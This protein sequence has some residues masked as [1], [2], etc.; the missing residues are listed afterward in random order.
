MNR[1]TML[2]LNA[3]MIACYAIVGHLL[4]NL[5]GHRGR[6][7][8]FQYAAPAVVVTVMLVIFRIMQGVT[9]VQYA[10]GDDEAMAIFNLWGTLWPVFLIGLLGV[11]VC[12]LTWSICALFHE[13]RLLL[14]PLAFL[15]VGLL[16]Q[17]FYTVAMHFPSV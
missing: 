12:Q 6:Y 4:L 16:C 1:E 15:G 2:L 10:A 14:A 5:A 11:G 17:T 7:H 13:D 3:A 8:V 9:T